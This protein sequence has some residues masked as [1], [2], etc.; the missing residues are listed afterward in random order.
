MRPI[1]LA[2]SKLLERR[3]KQHDQDIHKERLRTVK[4]A[5]R[6]Q[7]LGAAPYAH[8]EQVRTAAKEAVAESTEPH[9]WRWSNLS[10]CREVHRNRTGEPHPPRKDVEH[11]A[12]SKAQ[13]LQPE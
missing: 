12:R 8:N 9:A 3:W 4:S 7:F 1:R 2:S 11:H 6:S 5:V 10:F 13:T